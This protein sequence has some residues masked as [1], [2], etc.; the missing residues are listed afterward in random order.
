MQREFLETESDKEKAY[1]P[2]MKGLLAAGDCG[3]DRLTP[4][5]AISLYYGSAYRRCHQSPELADLW[6]LHNKTHS[7]S[8]DNPS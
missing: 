8:R 1:S 3:V 7:L 6:L 2:R 5:S 4:V